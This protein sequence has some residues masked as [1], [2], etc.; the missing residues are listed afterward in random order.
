LLEIKFNKNFQGASYW[1]ENVGVMFEGS[2]KEIAQ[3]HGLNILFGIALA[4]KNGF[5]ACTHENRRV[6]LFFSFPT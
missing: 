4:F 3:K 2:V 6:L 1:R 5:I